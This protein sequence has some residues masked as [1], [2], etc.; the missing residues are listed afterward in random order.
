MKR[1]ITNESVIGAFKKTAEL[2]LMSSSFNMIG[3]PTETK[4]EVFETLR[5]NATIQPD[6]IKLMTFYPFKNTPIYDMCEK[7][8]LI[9]YDKKRELDDYDSFSCL[10]FSKEHQLFLKKIQAVFNWYINVFLNT[11]GQRQCIGS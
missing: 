5:L 9:D 2:G 6:T 10:K 8:D 3:L 11:M 4:E 7:L 1:Q